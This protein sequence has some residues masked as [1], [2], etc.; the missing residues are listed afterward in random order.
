MKRLL[1]IRIPL[2]LLGARVL[3][4]GV[5]VAR[6]ANFNLGTMLLLGLGAAFIGYG[7]LLSRL[8]KWTWLHVTAGV[9]CLLL[10]GSAGALEVYGTRDNATYREDAVLVL[11]CG[12][13]GER[14]T[15][16][17][18]RRLD[19]AIA[20]HAQNPDAVIVVSGGQGA[21]ESI[22][23]AEAAARY[24][25][26]RGVPADK[27]IKEEQATS[28]VENF[29]YTAVPLNERFPDGYS[30][31][32]ITSRFHVFRAVRI[33]KKQGLTVT[34]VGAPVVRYTVP[35]NDLREVVAVLN[36]VRRGTI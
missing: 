14:V 3:Y 16:S 34:H 18:A 35:M 21:Q 7:L 26:E 19:A 5:H 12:I 13:D 9:C 32:V 23:E 10:V 17:L 36:E 1:F 2:I 25:T 4:N 6:T 28:T 24:L 20:Y 27:I 29:K 30:L 33:A 31:A 15:G 22:T 11:G 8:R